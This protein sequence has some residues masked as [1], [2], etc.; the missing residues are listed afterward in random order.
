MNCNF[1]VVFHAIKCFVV[2]YLKIGIIKPLFSI[3][4]LNGK[5]R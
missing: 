4:K 5:I 2:L 1:G 3:K